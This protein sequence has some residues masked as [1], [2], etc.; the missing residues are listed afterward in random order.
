MNAMGQQS[1][2]PGDA[3]AA[4]T[5][6]ASHDA[7]LTSPSERRGGSR[8]APL[9]SA[10]ATFLH[11]VPSAFVLLFRGSPGF[12]AIVGVLVTAYVLASGLAVSAIVS[13][14][15][16]QRTSIRRV[17]WW[18]PPLTVIALPF[19]S[20]TLLDAWSDPPVLFDYLYFI[21]SALLITAQVMLFLVG[22]RDSDWGA[23][24]SICA[25]TGALGSLGSPVV[26]AKMIPIGAWPAAYFVSLVFLGLT[27]VCDIT[28]AILPRGRGSRMKPNVEPET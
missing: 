21:P 8:G 9:R 6:P 24:A 26:S 12:V 2:S 14:V 11:L 17:P 5:E 28:L 19:I 25:V 3:A 22:T 16:S 15:R 23:S 4:E 10:A 1:H 20:A 18:V 27:F 7:A 13:A